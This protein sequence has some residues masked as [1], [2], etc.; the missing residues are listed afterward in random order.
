MRKKIACIVAFLANNL[1]DDLFFQQLCSRYPEAD[2]YAAAPELKNRSLEALENLHY[3]DDMK[4][5]RAEYL[6]SSQLSEETVRFFSQFDACVIIAGSIFMQWDTVY[7]RHDVFLEN[8]IKLSKK[9]FVI[10]ANFGP[11]YENQ[12]LEEFRQQFRMVED[13]CFRDTLSVSYFPGQKNVRYAPDII[14][15]CT[16]EKR[17]VK[18][19]VAVSVIDC[20]CHDRPG[21]QLKALSAAKEAYEKKM[22]S[23]ISAFYR[24]GYESCLVSFCAPQGDGQTAERIMQACLM[25]G[26]TNVS[27]CEYTGDIQPVMNTLSESAFFVA[28][29]F[30]AM[31][32]GWLFDRPTFPVIYD[33]K[34]TNVIR[35]FNFTNGYCDLT[36]FINLDADMVVNSL[37]NYKPFEIEQYKRDAQKQFTALD[38]FIKG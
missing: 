11:F 16:Y 5:M 19:Q 31:I 28:T 3:S 32:L 9:L 4:K 15:G 34:Q 37:K 20:A 36:E 24:E 30:H 25:N 12:F 35:D 10:G 2:F 17:P 1:G 23:L 27:H 26:V 18:K 29:R 6:G 7:K 33:Q 14:L 21:A 22:V 13:I 38:R 8:S